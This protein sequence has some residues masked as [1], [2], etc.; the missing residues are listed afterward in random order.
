MDM[1]RR[2]MG[3]SRTISDGGVPY[4]RRSVS[5]QMP[6]PGHPPG[7][8]PHLLINLV[9]S[10][11]RQVKR[12]SGPLPLVRETACVVIDG[13]WSLVSVIKHNGH[14]SLKTVIKQNLSR[15]TLYS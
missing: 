12:P 1:V 14:N 13:T 11:A 6:P 4:G 15:P 2:S 7:Q 5:D 9:K 10:P 3:P 8:M